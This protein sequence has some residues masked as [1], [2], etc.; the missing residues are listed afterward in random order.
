MLQLCAHRGRGRPGGV[1]PRGWRERGHRQP[2]QTVS[3]LGEMFPADPVGHGHAHRADGLEAPAPWCLPGN[4]ASSM[5]RLDCTVV[6]AVH[7]VLHRLC[8]RVAWRPGDRSWARRPSVWRADGTAAWLQ[9]HRPWPPTSAERAD[10]RCQL[11]RASCRPSGR[12]AARSRPCGA[13]ITVSG[14][15]GSEL[16]VR[17]PAGGKRRRR[18]RMSALPARARPG[19]R[20]IV[21][22]LQARG[23]Q[24]QYRASLEQDLAAVHRLPAGPGHRHHAGRAG[25]P[26]RLAIPVA[27]FHQPD[28]GATPARPGRRGLARPGGERLP[29][30]IAGALRHAC[31]NS[32]AKAWARATAA[33]V[34]TEDVPRCTGR[35]SSA[36][37][38]RQVIKHPEAPQGR[39]NGVRALNMLILDH[40]RAGGY[41]GAVYVFT[42]IKGLQVDHRRPGGLR[43]P[44]RHLG[45]ALH[46]CAAAARAA[47][48]RD[49]PG[50][51][52]AR[53]RGA[54]KAR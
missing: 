23:V 16:L 32:S 47:H 14:Y 51:G 43:E 24:V 15:E 40:D 45:A 20:R 50:R 37:T 38:R 31:A 17:T 2:A 28:L 34:W 9:R 46:R 33:G 26:S 13:R 35:S 21:E 29:W 30:P 44:A 5:R 52:A 39:R 8:A 36:D 10:R 42:A 25:L 12:H 41:W 7:P 3:L 19:R 48:R 18:C 49:R 27:L 54:P 53:P 4:G 1:R 11:Q 22:W 6:A